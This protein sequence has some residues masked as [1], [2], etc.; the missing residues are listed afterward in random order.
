MYIIIKL[1]LL[2]L[3]INYDGHLLFIFA[4]LPYRSVLFI[5]STSVFL[6]FVSMLTE[7]EKL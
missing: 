3:N 6:V 7:L 1:K 4:L 2:K 5:I